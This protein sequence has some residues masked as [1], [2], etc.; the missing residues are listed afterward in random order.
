V[1]AARSGGVSGNPKSTEGDDANATVD[2]TAHHTANRTADYH[3][4]PA[5][6]DT[7]TP[8]SDETLT[9]PGYDILGTLGRGGMG[10]VYHARQLALD[11]VVALKLVRNGAT[12]DAE[13]RERFTIEGRAL[14]RIQH[15]NIVQV[16]EVGEH[17]GTPFFTLEYLAG[18]S[19]AGYLKKRGRFSPYAAARLVQS[20]AD[21]M[22]AAHN[23]GILHRDLKPANVLLAGTNED[24]LQP[25]ITD[26]G[27]A[28]WLDR[29]DGPTVSGAVMGT[30]S[31]M[32]PEQATGEIDRLSAATDVYALGAT[33][34]E[35]L[36]GQPPFRAESSLATMALVIR[37][38]PTPPR[39]L[40]NEIPA[41]LEAI[42]LKCLEKSPANRYAS[43]AELRDDLGRFLRSE[44]TIARPLSRPQRV[45]RNLRKRRSAVFAGIGA[46]TLS[47]AVAGVVWA[48]RP[49]PPAPPGA[50]DPEQPLRELEAELAAGKPATLVGESGLPRWSR[51]P[52]YPATLTE[53]VSDVKPV[54]SFQTGDISL[55]ELVQ[56]P[57]ATGYRIEAE[58]RLD[59][60][61]S[62]DKSSTNIGIYWHYRRE[63]LANGTAAH[64][65]YSLEF[66]ETWGAF[67][68]PEAR[69][70]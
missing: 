40:R 22:S 48:L 1:C 29:A 46:I 12:L 16:F 42:C 41:E 6:H 8:A 69:A 17:D 50:P 39:R 35:C 67:E 9:L 25:K 45:W 47:I 13:Q 36:V 57:P 2:L 63:V 26:F 52:Y 66:N 53:S 30:P 51:W 68:T 5:T 18:G 43:A 49:E 19:L 4:Q 7:A 61:L 27:L 58:L 21:A 28:K 56:N 15:P 20:L 62:G 11:R 23:A 31:Y 38:E 54:A 32:A 33:L 24:N 59:R 37:A 34:Y 10:V 44:S 60:S 65:F 14:A 64:R 3:P 70:K 55:L